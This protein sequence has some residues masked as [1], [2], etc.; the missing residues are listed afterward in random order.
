MP[1]Q[2]NNAVTALKRHFEYS[3]DGLISDLTPSPWAK[4]HR[5]D[6]QFIAVAEHL[7]FEVR[8]H[9]DDLKA[10]RTT[11]ENVPH[12]TVWFQCGPYRLDCFTESHSMM[13]FWVATFKQEGCLHKPIAKIH[14]SVPNGGLIAA[15]VID[16]HD[17]LRAALK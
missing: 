14:V 6:L 7:G 15:G 1:D 4:M 10:G 11:A 3:F 16:A 12:N 9:P 13:T 2:K 17:R 8:Y 5:R